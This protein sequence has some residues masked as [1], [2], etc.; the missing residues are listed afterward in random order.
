MIVI[1]NCQQL[2][3]IYIYSH[4]HDDPISEGYV[5]RQIPKALI[6]R[7]V[8]NPNQHRQPRDSHQKHLDQT[9]NIEFSTG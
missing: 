6:P 3:L 2:M 4:K 9:E 5:D 8:K 1:Y 7:P